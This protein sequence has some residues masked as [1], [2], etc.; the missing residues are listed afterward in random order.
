MQKRKRK[1]VNRPL[2]LKLVG[3][4]TA[5]GAVAALLQVILM[6]AS[7]SE[8][9]QSIPSDGEQVL[10]ASR[11]IVLKNTLWT[12][13]ALVPLMAGVG[14]VATSHIA[15]PTY[16]MTQHL[17]EIAAGG[18]VRTC[19][20]REHDEFSELC[21]A[22]NAALEQL[23]PPGDRGEDFSEDWTQASPSAEMPSQQSKA[24]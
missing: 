24:A 6:N 22:L 13:G 20:I 12:L 15:G 3:I 4:F 18:P 21:D 9:A 7:L 16:R 5:I 23:A 11:A 19:E 14:I 8:L 2:Q 10:E 1:L 17:K